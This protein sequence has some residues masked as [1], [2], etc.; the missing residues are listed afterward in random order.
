MPDLK[1]N[2]DATSVPGIVLALRRELAAMLVDAG[3]DEVPAV[4]ERLEAIARAF[5]NNVSPDGCD[6]ATPGTDILTHAKDCQWRMWKET[7]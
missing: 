7:K 2:I 3:R 5:V 1:M 4:R 6:C